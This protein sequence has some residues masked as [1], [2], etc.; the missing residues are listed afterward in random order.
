MPR[1]PRLF[2]PLGVVPQEYLDVRN[3]MNTGDVIAFA[4]SDDFISSLIRKVTGSEYSHVGIVVRNKL[5]PGLKDSI[6]LVEAGLNGSYQDFVAKNSKFRI[7]ARSLSSVLASF[8]GKVW[9]AGLKKPL[10]QEETLALGAWLEEQKDKPYDWTQAGL[11]GI[12]IF[13]ETFLPLVETSIKNGTDFSAFFCSELVAGALQ[14]AG[15]VSNNINPSGLTPKEV[16]KL[17][18]LKAAVPIKNY[19]NNDTEL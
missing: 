5:V 7:Q 19:S 13:S 16:M 15:E 18:C 11:L 2:K 12:E 14:A 17:P 1:P 4:D 6:L 9:W 3:N 10:S 8:S